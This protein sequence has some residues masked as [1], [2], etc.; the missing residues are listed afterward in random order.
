MVRPLSSQNVKKYIVGYL[1][2]VFV[3]DFIVLMKNLD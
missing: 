2:Y 1:S 3:K